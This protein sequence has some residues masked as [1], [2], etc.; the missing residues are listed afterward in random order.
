M[1]RVNQA[2][3]L[4]QIT[5]E[6]RSSL[7]SQH[8]FQAT[9]DQVGQA[10][11]VSRCLLYLCADYTD[12]QPSRML[13]AAEYRGQEWVSVA[14]MDFPLD[15]TAYLQQVMAEDTAIAL[16]DVYADSLSTAVHHR[17]REAELKS[18]LLCRTS[19]QN[20]PNSVI[21]L[22]QCDQYRVWTEDEIL[23]LESVA[24]QVGIA[25]YHGHLLE[26]AMKQQA[27]LEAKNQELQQATREAEAASRSKSAF[28][29]AMNHELRTPLNIILG[30]AQILQSAA[31]LPSD[32]RNDAS[33]ILESGE[34]LLN[35][36]NSLLTL[37]K[38]Q[39]GMIP[40][41]ECTFDIDEFINSIELIVAQQI[42]QKGLNF[43][44]DRLFDSPLSVK[45]DE[46]KVCQIL[47]HLF[48]NAIKFTD[49][50]TIRLA[51]TVTSRDASPQSADF[52]QSSS[53]LASLAEPQA[54][55]KFEVHDTGC[56][57]A[58][59][60]LAHIF[61]AAAG[62]ETGKKKSAE[63]TGLG[64]TLSQEIARLI[65]GTLSVTSVVNDGS[66]FSIKV[67]VC[68][69]TQARAA[70]TTAAL[71][72]KQSSQAV[73]ALPQSLGVTN[74]KLSTRLV[75][76]DFQHFSS[77]WIDQ[78]YDA[79]IRCDDSGAQQLIS[80]LG[81]NHEAIA[82]KIQHLVDLFQFEEIIQ[83]IDQLQRN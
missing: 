53:N 19:Y 22:Q 61:N 35:L 37:A 14:Q 60:E 5:N 41:D 1:V 9:V 25:L 46:G 15:G 34:R 59:D 56:G 64:L 80:E 47:M 28:L 43:T 48:D 72:D 76:E 70:S 29:A 51:V 8:I 55:V 40:L 3:L 75:P 63:G 73:A 68:I 57:I 38:L 50:G 82:A 20:S 7:D 83:L 32:Y 77:E 12:T 81:P 6:I 52:A 13:F 69:E 78:L 42:Q 2:L 31:D 18:I 24:A 17:W 45:T 44:T 27:E 30:F 10:F 79:A 39:A 49:K 23:L 16:S 4:G 66:C 21:V 62:R 74:P 33:L 71:T 65:G 36:I 26:N 67:P 11:Q 58:A 54:W